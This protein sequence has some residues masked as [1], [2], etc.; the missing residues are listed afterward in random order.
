M[1]ERRRSPNFLQRPVYDVIVAGGG[2]AGLSAAIAASTRGLSVVVCEQRVLPAD[3]AC[4]EGLMP[5][6]LRA[7]EELGVRS[8]I[9]SR[10]CA[11]LEGVRLIGSQR[12]MVEAPLPAPG[13]LG[14]RRVVLSAALRHRAR[15]AGVE[16]R[17][18]CKV[19]GYRL[20]RDCIVAQTAGGEVRGRV[21]IAADGL[22]SRLR[23]TAGLERSARGPRRYGIRQH[24][25]LPP[26]SR[27]I[28][29]HLGDAI[30]AYV[31]P[32]S[33]D[34]VGVALLWEDRGGAHDR[35]SFLEMLRRFPALADRIADAPAQSRP[36]GAGPMHQ[37]ARRLV[38]DRFALAGDAAGYVDAITGEGLSLA[39]AAGVELGRILPRAIAMDATRSSLKEYERRAV[40]RLRGYAFSAGSVLAVARRPMVRGV[41]MSVLERMPRLFEWMLKWTFADAGAHPQTSE[42]LSPSCPPA[43]ES[44]MSH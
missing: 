11:P 21:M 35:V 27:F 20:S 29:V 6:A 18:Q 13:A 40:R 36:R 14:V 44:M 9:D 30:E 28:E 10:N 19:V 7:L 24:F 25:S 39:L 33:P 15:A 43:R 17:E 2:P 3:K 5:P 1:A 41:T 23:K 4:G 12:G 26:W 31:T 8:L 22:R 32:I 16:I 34:S 37:R 38:A 42:E